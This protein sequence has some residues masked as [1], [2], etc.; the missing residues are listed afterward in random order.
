[1]VTVA[2]SGAGRCKG[3]EH[4]MLEAVK[5]ITI[6]TQGLK[7]HVGA[8]CTEQASASRER[9]LEPKWLWNISAATLANLPTTTENKITHNETNNMN[10]VQITQFKEN[11][12]SDL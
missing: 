11:I 1:M 3:F 8:M 4:G 7:P 12:N 2:F 5:D 10:K 9:T 6:S